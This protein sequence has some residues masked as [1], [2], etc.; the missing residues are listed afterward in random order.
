M[1]RHNY[2]LKY[3]GSG[4]GADKGLQLLR[5][6]T[7][8]KILDESAYPKMLLVNAGNEIINQLKTSLLD[9][10]IMPEKKISLPS[11]RKRLKK[12]IGLAHK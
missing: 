12:N 4:Q 2:I 10:L 5:S 6:V 7:D 1:L 3:N 8:V 11:T 9:W